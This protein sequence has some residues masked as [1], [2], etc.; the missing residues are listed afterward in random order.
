MIFVGCLSLSLGTAGCYFGNSVKT[1]PQPED[2]DKL[3][4][5]YES[6]PVSL[7]FCATHLVSRTPSSEPAPQTTPSPL[8][9]STATPTPTTSSTPAPSQPAHDADPTSQTTQCETVSTAQIPSLFKQRITDPLALY[10]YDIEGRRAVLANPAIKITSPTQGLPV[11]IGEDQE[12]IS[13]VLGG[14]DSDLNWDASDCTLSSYSIEG[15][16]KITKTTGQA[17]VSGK[18]VTTSGRVSL[19]AFWIRT[20]EG[21]CAER[22]A[23]MQRCY[24]RSEDCEGGS[25]RQNQLLQDE[26]HALLDEFIKAGVLKTSQI[27]NLSNLSYEVTYE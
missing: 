3:T 12:T 19:T 6:R 18:K 17:I 8:P 15:L 21:N 22:T 23:A 24:E 1:A 16:G 26:I 25:E 13:T 9:T 20:F 14:F 5:Y 11:R 27:S 2:P 4:G 7:K 10:Y